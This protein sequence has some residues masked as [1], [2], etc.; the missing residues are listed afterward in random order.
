MD[1]RRT[2]LYAEGIGNRKLMNTPQHVDVA[3]IG[4]GTAG[5]SAQREVARHTDS[6][7]VIDPGPLGTTCARA[8]CMPS[9]A[10]IHVA[11]LYDR[12]RRA[13]PGIETAAAGVN[14]AAVLRHVRE[15]RDDFVAGVLDGMRPWRESHLIPARARFLDPCTLDIDG[16]R[17]SAGRTIIATGSQPGLPQP[18]ARFRAH[19]LDS[20]RVFDLDDLPGSLAVIGLGPVGIELAQ[21]LAQLGTAVTGIDPGRGIGGLSD[22]AL[23]DYAIDT[24]AETLT[25]HFAEAAIE[26][27]DAD[28][29]RVVVNDVTVGA[30]AALVATGRPPAVDGLGLDRLGVPL[31][32]HGVPEFNRQT[33]QIGDL[34]VFMA[35]DVN[36]VRPVLHEAADEGRIAAWNALRDE[37]ACFERHPPLAITFTSPN[38]ALVG[39]RF[40]ELDGGDTPFVTGTARFERQGRARLMDAAAG[41]LH[42]YAARDDGR[43]LGAEL[44]APAGEHLAHLLAWA[45]GAGMTV[46]ELMEMP[47]YHPV[48]EEALRAALRDAAKRVERAFDPARSMRCED[49]PVR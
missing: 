48:I 19:L 40:T 13:P 3:I 37:P 31:D 7:R 15:L 20:E 17:L 22:P 6:Y 11:A 46:S 21:A 1:F 39:A 38:I 43:L 2:A 26:H 25:L 8:A 16:A 30:E 27:A 29:V 24:F 4:A 34:P 33:L 28:E 47:F 44:F 12:I 14:T 23:Q 35:G 41:R 10:L 9:K 36:G 32:D 42:V 49:Y 45:I 5:L 18:W